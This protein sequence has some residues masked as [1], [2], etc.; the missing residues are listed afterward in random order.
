M[1]VIQ[2]QSALSNPAYA[3]PSTH[4]EGHDAVN[5]WQDY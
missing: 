2:S 4:E 1:S 3:L 5:Q